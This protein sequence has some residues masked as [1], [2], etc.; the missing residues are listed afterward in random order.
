MLEIAGQIKIVQI[1]VHLQGLYKYYKGHLMT[2]EP[3]LW[4]R[5]SEKN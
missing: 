4:Q 5:A 2:T 1:K 3:T